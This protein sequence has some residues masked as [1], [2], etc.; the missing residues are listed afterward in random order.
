MI[1]WKVQFCF[2]FMGSFLEYKYKVISTADFILKETGRV[3]RFIN[4]LCAAE[5]INSIPT[6]LSEG[7]PHVQSAAFSFNES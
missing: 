5:T 2:P 1:L 4:E 7:S 6:A 3:C